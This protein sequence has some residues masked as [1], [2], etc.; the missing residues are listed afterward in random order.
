[1]GV[2]KYNKNK[3]DGI[4]EVIL[5]SGISI[6]PVYTP[7]DLEDVGFDYQKDLADPGK[8]PFTRG[9]HPLGYRSRAWTTRQYTGF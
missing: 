9:I 7:K 2:A 3:K 4:E 5:Q 8:Y 6:K 1:M